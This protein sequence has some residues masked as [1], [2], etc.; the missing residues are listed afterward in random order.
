MKLKR[1]VRGAVVGLVAL[2]GPVRGAVEFQFTYSDAGSGFN[3]PTLGAER[4]SSLETAAGRL[5]AYFSG[6]NAVLEITV[7]SYS[8]AVTTLAAASSVT[9]A[10]DG[11]QGTVMQREVLNGVDLQP[12]IADANLSVNFFH[13]WG[14]GDA[15]PDSAYDFQSVAMHEL[16]HALGFFSY[17]TADG[18]GAGGSPSG[19]P[20]TWT[21]FDR[22]LTTDAGVRLVGEDFRYNVG[23]DTAVL[24][25]DPGVYFSGPNAMAAY[26]GRVPIYS[27]SPF[28]S[29]SSLGHVDDLGGGGVGLLMYPSLEPGLG[30]RSFSSVEIGMLKD[31]GF[32]AVPEVEVWGTAGALGLVV[33]AG[34]RRRRGQG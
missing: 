10:S 1:V 15:V 32:T 27:P 30:A 16:T 34:W 11:F 28:R 17:I 22:N 6:Y 29:G 33:F 8:S 14:Y 20:D 4:R 21:V 3:H 7:S 23:V 24:T 18:R 9:S 13:E 5:G 2:A 26:G 25:A 19:D 12:G 31:I